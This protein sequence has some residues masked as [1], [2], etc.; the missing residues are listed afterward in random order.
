MRRIVRI[1]L[2]FLV[3]LAGLVLALPGVPGPGFVLVLFGL[4]LLS[5]HFTWA[6]RA[7]DWAKARAERLK[8]KA[9]L[10]S[11]AGQQD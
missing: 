9:G 10:G 4:V 11:G 7:L 3:L 8:Q 2:G 6:R 5:E 1:A